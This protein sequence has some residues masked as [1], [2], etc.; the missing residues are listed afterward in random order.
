[1]TP[2]QRRYAELRAAGLGQAT[3]AKQ[4]GYALSSAKVIASRMEKLPEIREAIDAGRRKGK[5]AADGE[6]EFAS[7]EL[8]LRAVVQG[9]TAPDPVR[10]GAAR[11]LLPFETAKTRAP[12]Q[13]PTPRTLVRRE[14][15]TLDQ[16]ARDAWNAKAA[17]IRAQLAKK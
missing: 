6:P 4:A 15:Q 8:Y 7:A 12:L 9:T 5:P 11:A 10:V 2:K 14:T 17:K 3:S 13:S 1:M 16:A